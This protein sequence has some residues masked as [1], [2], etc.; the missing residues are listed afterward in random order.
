MRRPAAGAQCPRTGL[1]HGHERRARRRFQQLS[2][3]PGAD[4]RHATRHRA[5]PAGGA[6]N[7]P[8]QRRL[9]AARLQALEQTVAASAKATPRRRGK[10]QRLTLLLAGAFGLV[11]AGHHAADGLFPVAR[12]HAARGDFRRSST[13]A[14]ANATR[15]I[16]SPR[17]AAHGG[18]PPT[19]GCSN[20]V[21]QLEKRIHELEA[22]R[23]CCRKSRRSKPATCW[24][25]SK[26]FSTRNQPQKALECVEKFLAAQP[27]QCRGAGQAGGGAGET[28]AQRRGAGELDRAI[29]ADGT[30][31]IAHLHKGGL[32][33]RLRRYD[34]ALDC[35]ERA[36][37]AQE[38]KVKV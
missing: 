25:T 38:K 15:F 3:D 22:D 16:S 11:G 18:K 37:V 13:P 26:N 10:T 29:A 31:A 1:R 12:V 2:P 23:N 14:I 28:G 34:E 32:L 19:R 27:G 9:L 36:L 4:S 6:R 21:D 35:Y 17:R 30:L 33:N 7:R 8:E 5:K 20:V 24:R